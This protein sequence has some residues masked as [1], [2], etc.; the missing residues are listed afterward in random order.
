MFLTDPELVFMS[1]SA[2]IISYVTV[3]LT[4][5]T[6]NSDYLDGVEWAILPIMILMILVNIVSVHFVVSWTITKIVSPSD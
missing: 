5:M 6:I 3:W 4:F 2:I 1:F